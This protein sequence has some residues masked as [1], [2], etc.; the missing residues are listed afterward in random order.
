MKKNI[1]DWA[2]E[3]RGSSDVMFTRLC[4]LERSYIDDLENK[5]EIW[6]S[7]MMKTILGRMDIEDCVMALV[8]ECANKDCRLTDIIE[9]VLI[10]KKEEYS[11]D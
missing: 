7:T 9:K 4:I 1:V 11:K 8:Y 6:N 10:S 2:G 5:V 3:A